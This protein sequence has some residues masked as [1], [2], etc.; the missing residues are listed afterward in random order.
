MAGGNNLKFT[1]YVMETT[2]EPLHLE[3][4][5]LYNER[6]WTYLKVL[7]EELFSLTELKNMATG[8]FSKF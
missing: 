4:E 2:H 6:S 7:C 5:L 1:F 3:N 8:G